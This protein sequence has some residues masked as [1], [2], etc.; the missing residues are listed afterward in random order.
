MSD[1]LFC[2]SCPLADQTLEG[3]SELVKPLSNQP[4]SILVV[5]DFEDSRSALR[6][7]LEIEGFLILEAIDGQQASE[8]A[9][10][11]LPDLIL[12]DL[13]LP[14]V[15][16]FQATREIRAAE[17]CRALPIIIVSAHDTNEMRDEARAAGCTDYITKPIDFDQLRGLIRKYIPAP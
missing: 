17:K 10:R 7:L 13:S 2:L 3:I 5:E 8:T 4:P 14:T 6:R 1:G 15:N 9:I 11:E 12:M 16:G